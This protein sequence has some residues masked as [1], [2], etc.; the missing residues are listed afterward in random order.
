[1]TTD[2]KP[3]KKTSKLHKVLLSPAIIAYYHRHA[4]VM[5]DFSL[6]KEE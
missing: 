4:S 5:P 1:M 6:F 2:P 3:K